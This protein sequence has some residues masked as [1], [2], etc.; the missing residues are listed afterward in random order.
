MI[1]NPQGERKEISIERLFSNFDRQPQAVVDGK[2]SKLPFEDVTPENFERLIA[3]LAES[4]TGS[5]V[6]AFRYGKPGS[7]QEGIDVVVIDARAGLC[8]YYEGK[9]RAKV[10]KGQITAWI[11]KFLA[12]EHSADARRFVICTTFNVFEVTDLAKEWKHCAM[13]LAKHEIDGDLWDG[14]K[15]QDMLRHRPDIVREMFSDEVA[16]R[17]CVL[18]LTPLPEPPQQRFEAQRIVLFERSLSLQN[19][20]V[21]CEVM[22]PGKGEMKTGALLSFARRDLSGISISI[23]G[24]DLVQWMQWRVHA[25]IHATRPFAPEMLDDSDRVVLMASTARLILTKQEA[26]HLDWVLRT[27]WTVFYKNAAEELTRYRC[28]SFS[29]LHGSTGPFV[30]AS[31]D[32]TLWRAMLEFARAHDFADGEGRWYMFDSAPGCLKPYTHQDNERFDRGYHAVL[33]AYNASGIWLPWERR[34]LIGWDVPSDF[35]SPAQVSP[36]A[37]WDAQFTHDWLL[38]ELIPEVLRWER[39]SLRQPVRKS[40]FWNRSVSVSTR[41]QSPDISALAWSAASG[42]SLHTVPVEFDALRDCVA[43]LQSHFN[44][45][46]SAAEIEPALSRAVLL[47]IDRVMTFAELEHEGYLRGCLGIEAAE[48]LSSGVR[49]RARVDAHG[50]SQ[51]A[52][53]YRLRGLLEVLEAA[54]D[55][56]LGEWRG[57]AAALQPVLDRYNEDRVCDIFTSGVDL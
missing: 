38:E 40:R 35:S 54:G 46:R 53:D 2:I 5:R 18:A 4:P 31:V 49:A 47:A 26:E 33:Y 42:S 52:M 29:R 32:R 6:Q 24:K 30:L 17:F 21:H 51:A 37:N 9:R 55:L 10:A 19:V 48:P 57:I 22:L 39:T 16:S 23:S 27:A 45:R 25:P 28:G 44:G 12:G 13:L 7:T 50:T 1:M 14:Q 34:V 11:E 15:I 43:M 41:T 3:R 8:D 36:R 56:P 20:S